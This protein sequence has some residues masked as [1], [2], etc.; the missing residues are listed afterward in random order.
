MSFQVTD[1]GDSV[2]PVPVMEVRVVR[3]TV[4]EGGVLVNVG[5]RLPRRVG[6][7]MLMLMM[8]VVAV[9]MRM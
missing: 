1:L 5:V 9:P 6:G 8:R 4:R 2:V 7:G 3:V